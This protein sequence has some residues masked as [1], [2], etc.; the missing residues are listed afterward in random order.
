MHLHLPNAPERF[1]SR[2][3][4]VRELFWILALGALIVFAFFLML[5]ALD[6]A[7]VAGLTI[8]VCVLA[9]LWVVHAW[10]GRR[11]AGE[12]DERLIRAR[13]RRGF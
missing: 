8:G 5:G 9:A 12:H 1:A 4:T 6:P 7:E 10:L 11:H 13:E 2:T 3:Q